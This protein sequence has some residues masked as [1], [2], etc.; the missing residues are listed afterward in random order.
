MSLIF[1]PRKLLFATALCHLALSTPSLM[2]QA[3]SLHKG[4]IAPEVSESQKP[5]PA[6]VVTQEQQ[7]AATAKVTEAP[8]PSSTASGQRAQTAQQADANV[9]TAPSDSSKALAVTLSPS[10]NHIIQGAA[11][12]LDAEFKNTS[13]TTI[14]I[15]LQTLS[16]SVQPELGPAEGMCAYPYTIS[17]TT[18]PS[19]V[20]MPG[21][22]FTAVFDL[23]AHIYE[24]NKADPCKATK[25]DRVRKWIDFVPGNYSF[26][27]SGSYW[28]TKLNPVSNVYDPVIVHSFSDTTSL[29]VTID[30]AQI[31][32]YAALGG[33]LAWGIMQMRKSPTTSTSIGTKTESGAPL[34]TRPNQT[35]DYAEQAHDRPVPDEAGAQCSGQIKTRESR[36]ERWKNISSGTS[37]LLRSFGWVRQAFGA[38]LMSVTITVVAGRLST[39]QFPV[40]VSVDDF[41]GALTVGFVSYF[42]GGKFIDRLSATTSSSQT[43]P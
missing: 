16:L 41:W 29:P 37:S 24:P 28:D 30:Q 2:A 7:M 5:H 15:P 20:L 13:Q 18:V 43:N 38:M 17:Q 22:N 1:R 42:V 3:E 26:V 33:L 9:T 11:Y 32:F 35:G 14:L 34:H 39:T 6:V 8:V 31:V 25:I 23:G 36:R 12:G 19:I 10:T 4:P 27:M 21:D 40:K